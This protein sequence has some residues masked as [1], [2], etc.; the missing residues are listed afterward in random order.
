MIM[1][2]ET[3]LVPS[4][5]IATGN[6][7][8]VYRHCGTAV[9]EYRSASLADVRDYVRVMNRCVSL[10]DQI[11]YRFVLPIFGERY[12][13]SF[14]GVC[15]DEITISP[16]G[17]PVTYSSY[18]TEPNL[19]WLTSEEGHF[20]KYSP[21]DGDSR[22]WQ[23]FTA[24]NTHFNRERPTRLRDEFEYH[25][26]MFSRILDFHLGTFGLYIGKYNVKPRPDLSSR[27]LT[28]IVTD[29]AVYLSRVV[30]SKNYSA[31]LD[32]ALSLAAQSAN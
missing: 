6:D 23:F 10:I 5:K 1:D 29:V 4:N 19:D 22:N 7:S 9:K 11:N 28:L 20:A 2:L 13:V 32:L 27:N 26:C 12:Q 30:H 31:A 15:V 8:W 21:R 17:R 16:A 18:I 25:L 3:I 14:Q 24:L